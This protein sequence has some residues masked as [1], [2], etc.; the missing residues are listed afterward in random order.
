MAYTRKTTSTEVVEKNTDNTVVEKIEKPKTETKKTIK[1]YNPEDLIPCTSITEGE[2]GMVG[3]RSETY[4][5]WFASG[6]T[7]DIEYRDLIAEILSRTSRY[8]Y[9]PLFII[10]DEELINQNPAVADVYDKMYSVRDLN[11]ILDMP[12]GQMETIL[13]TL[14]KGAINNIKIL[15]ATNIQNGK[16]DS[17]KKINLIDEV[18]GTKLLQELELFNE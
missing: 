16:L 14:P 12:I 10:E 7:I 8:I 18:C 11:D 3:K 2:L 17:L 6:E 4:Y 9:D 13:P 15:A 1:K 5:R